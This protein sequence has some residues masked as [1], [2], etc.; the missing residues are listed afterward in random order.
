M[1]KTEEFLMVPVEKIIISGNNPRIINEK[2]QEFKEL[3]ESIMAMGV[4][5]PVH[6][7]S[8][9]K[10]KDKYELLAGERRLL[11]AGRANLK[12][13]RAINH[14][15]IGD[16]EAFEIT[17]AENFGREDLTPLEQ[18]KAV[19]I[20][21]EKY[22]GDTKAVA[23]KMGKSISWVLQRAAI[24][25]NLSKN[26]KKAITE[27]PDF[28]N[29]TASHL[30]L[31]AAFPTEVQDELF[32]YNEDFYGNGNIISVAKL[33]KE[34]KERLML[35]SG[36]IWKLDDETLLEEPKACNKCKQRSSVQPGLFDDTTDA[37]QVKK[38]DRCLNRNCWD[39]KMKAY[40]NIQWNLLRNQHKT[41]FCIAT[42]SPD[43]NKK[44][45][46]EQ[47]YPCFLRD[48][49]K[50]EEG[51]KGA[52]AALVVSGPDI[53]QVRWVRPLSNSSSGS[54]SGSGSAGKKTGEKTMAEKKEALAGK[55]RA[56]FLIEIAE[57][58]KT[59]K[60]DE[61]ICKDKEKMVMALAFVF[62]VNQP[63]SGITPYYINHGEQ[64]FKKASNLIATEKDITERLWES[65]REVLI[66]NLRYNGPVTQTPVDRIK[67]ALELAKLFDLDVKK[68]WKKVEEKI[69]EPKSWAKEKEGGKTNKKKPKVKKGVC[70]VC[71]CT[72][73]NP[74]AEGCAWADKDKTICTKCIKTKSKKIKDKK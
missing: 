43:Y 29:W 3:V 10:Q 68:I 70:R 44:Y 50:S 21:M 2:S 23:S 54:G 19:A 42:D 15:T 52:E 65:V 8:H 27:D 14:G 41:I 71:G 24:S 64:P 33:D 7:R 37:E 16:E 60:A 62:G 56:G 40:L 49:K 9:P 18:G 12:E 51:A 20:L 55:R 36:A 38:N 53:G 59:K 11:A 17:F 72:E 4:I 31:I 47:D 48:W 32:E 5:V 45:Q 13:L 57:I 74:C 58:V 46:L 34:L 6:V 28:K 35:I 25:K 22:K 63:Y 61:L 1:S 69:P 26:W 67:E 73:D 39:E 30:Q 66:N